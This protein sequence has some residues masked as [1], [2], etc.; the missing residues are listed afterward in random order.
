MVDR[1][2]S[3]M[4]ANCHPMPPLRVCGEAINQVTDF[5]YL[6]SQMA[7]SASSFKRRRALA[8]GAFWKLERFWKFR[9]YPFQPKSVFYTTCVTV[10]YMA[11]NPGCY[12]KIWYAKS[13]HL[14]LLTTGSCWILNEKDHVSTSA[15]YSIINT[16]PL[17]HH[18]RKRQL[19][20]RGHILRL[21]EE[22]P[23]NR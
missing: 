17:V 9:N 10:V 23:V 20:F 7:S 19:S 21:P 15:V 5:K 11:T 16:E 22:E 6:G 13:M 1:S 8:S 14:P 3:D 2:I 12:L 4:T 18:W